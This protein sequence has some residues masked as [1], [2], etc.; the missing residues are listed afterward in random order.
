MSPAGKF[1]IEETDYGNIAEKEIRTLLDEKTT[2]SFE[3]IK[4]LSAT[5]VTNILQSVP[6]R[7]ALPKQ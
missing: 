6:E 1:L 7:P 4:P 5:N 3:G 2:V